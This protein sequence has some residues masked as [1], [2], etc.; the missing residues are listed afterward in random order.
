[1]RKL[2][3]KEYIVP[4]YRFSGTMYTSY[5]LLTCYRNVLFELLVELATR[6]AATLTLIL[7]CRMQC[8]VELL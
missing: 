2:C 6:A 1:M 3:R 5:N 7:D 4:L 8:S